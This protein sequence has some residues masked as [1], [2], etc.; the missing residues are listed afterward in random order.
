MNGMSTALMDITPRPAIS[1]V[2][3]EGA[4]LT[5]NHGKRY[6]DFIQGWAVNCLGH[7]PAIIA[8]TLA[9]QAAT[10]INCSPSF[11]N[12]PMLTLA[13][14]IVKHSGLHKVFFTSSGAE[15]N[16][17]AIKLARRWG[18]KH[19]DGAY[20]II[21]LHN[22]FHGRT[23]ATMSASGKPQWE[24][25]FEPKVTGFKKVPINNI[26]AITATITGNTVAVMLEP[27]QGEGGVI[28][29]TREYLQALRQ[30]TEQHNILLILDEVQTGMGRLGSLF[31]FQQAGIKPDIFT[32]GKGLGAGVPLAA[33]VA[34]NAVSCFEHGDQ[35]GT[36][37]GTPLMTAVGNAVFAVVSQPEFLQNV[38][39]RGEYLRHQLR[40]LS[41]QFN[42]GEV[43]GEGLLVALDVPQ[44][45]ANAIA[46]EAFAQGLI[47]NA[48]RPTVL[49]FMPALNVSEAEIDEMTTRLTSVLKKI[50]AA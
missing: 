41:T 13:E 22:S 31:A 44:G 17:G 32:L 4:W 19:K 28:P 37:S 45:N 25:L 12:T 47:I 26:D 16:E 30:L 6:L 3:G 9:A 27:V 15:A 39:T 24:S 42:L 10:L 23:L 40:A 48:T 18:E 5:D 49:R 38:I 50:F 46:A 35:G 8:E 7:S 21:T 1:M 34:S 29:A 11:Y 2:T 36:F 14:H 20:D 43:R 33:M